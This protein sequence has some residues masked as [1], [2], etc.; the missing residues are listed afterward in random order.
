MHLADFDWNL[1]KI[2][3][4]L[5]QHGNVSRAAVDLGLTQSAVSHALARARAHFGD[6]LFVRVS[7]GI[8]PTRFGATLEA[9]IASLSRAAQSLG[10]RKDHFDPATAQGRIVVATTEYFEIVAM[11]RLVRVLEKK[12]PHV[13]VSVRSTAASL[14]R[15]DLEAGETHLAVAGFFKDLPASYHQAA[16]FSDGFL[17]VVRRGHPALKS[18]S[19]ARAEFLKQRHALLTLRG[20]F[21]EVAMLECEEK[22]RTF[23][24][25]SSS[26]TA[27]A[28]VVAASDLVMTAPER[29]V[30]AFEGH[31]DFVSFKTP[32]ALDPLRIKMVWHARTHADPLH[33]WFRKILRETIAGAGS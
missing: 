1:L 3:D 12:A 4:A 18:K 21:E 28:W 7:K 22:G 6:P 32:L 25:G 17:S 15:S 24:Y 14:P 11:P 2:L 23:A 13:Q 16:L 33:V 19:I 9:E 8:V 29:L 5:F 30:N 31:F 10:A 26:F 20:D 27:V